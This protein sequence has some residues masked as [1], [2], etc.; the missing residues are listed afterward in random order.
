VV[1]V[2]LPRPPD[3]PRA[4]ALA[5]LPGRPAVPFPLADPPDRPLAVPRAPPVVERARPELEPL[6]VPLDRALP[7]PRRAAPPRAPPGGGVG[8]ITSGDS[9]L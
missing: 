3:L 9:S 4:L 6:A 8:S 1:P 5:G 2:D 7:E